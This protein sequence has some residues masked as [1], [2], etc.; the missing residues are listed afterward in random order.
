MII[1]TFKLAKTGRFDIFIIRVGELLVV[2]IVSFFGNVEAIVIG[3]RSGCSLLQLFIFVHEGLSTIL[4]KVSRQWAFELLVC[5]FAIWGEAVNFFNRVTIRTGVVNRR[6]RMSG[7]KTEIFIIILDFI[8]KC[9]DIIT[10]WF[11][12][13]LFIIYQAR[14]IHLII[15]IV[16]NA[17][18]WTFTMAL[19]CFKLWRNSIFIGSRGPSA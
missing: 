4:A 14:I 6:T 12:P 15:S 3:S 13:S 11:C 19:I 8:Y 18:W 7:S 16:R 17:K 9:F 2:N 1:A 5:I 10:S